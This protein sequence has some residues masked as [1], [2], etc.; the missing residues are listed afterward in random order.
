MNPS[1]MDD[2][3]L[4][5]LLQVEVQ[6]ELHTTLLRVL[7]DEA[8][9]QR[10]V[11]SHEMLLD[12]VRFYGAGCRPEQELRMGRLLAHWL[13]A[14]HVSVASDLLGAAHALCGDRA[15]IV[16]ILGTGSG[17]ALYDGARFVQSTPSLGYILGDEGS[18]ASLGKHLLADVFKGLL[19]SHLV[20]AFLDTYQMD[21]ATAIQHIYRESSPNRYLAHFTHFLSDHQHEEAI[22]DFLVREFRLF[23]HRNIAAYHRP[24]LKVNFVGSIASIFHKELTEAAEHEGFHVGRILRS[25]IE[26]LIAPTSYLRE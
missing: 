18:G 16:C 1:L 26:A 2:D 13:R 21:V 12:R 7:P 14:R 22:H 23:F 25:P 20:D 17:S 4:K 8:E 3:T 15:G 19:P 6:P 10:H 24:D 11:A 5:R 9:S